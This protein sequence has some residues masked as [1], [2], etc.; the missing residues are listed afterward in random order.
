[1]R[2]FS[3]QA[4]NYFPSSILISCQKGEISQM[5]PLRMKCWMEKQTFF[6]SIVAAKGRNE[7]SV[8]LFIFITGD[9]PL[10]DLLNP[11]GYNRS[12]LLVD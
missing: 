7:Y 2:E 10:H 12:G 6:F 3:A 9:L 5:L 4:M 8:T 1:M 11:F